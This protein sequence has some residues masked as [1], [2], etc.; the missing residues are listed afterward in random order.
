M[1]SLNMNNYPSNEETLI[2]SIVDDIYKAESKI[3]EI[4]QNQNQYNENNP[5]Q[6]E[7]KEEK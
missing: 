7:I 6:K 3:T 2:H 5:H 1:Y 4:N